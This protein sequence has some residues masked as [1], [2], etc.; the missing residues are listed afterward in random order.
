MVLVK[1]KKNISEVQKYKARNTKSEYLKNK[2]NLHIN[3]PA[4]IR[5]MQG[6]T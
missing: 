6:Q 3:L 2:K 4:N 1:I 5:F